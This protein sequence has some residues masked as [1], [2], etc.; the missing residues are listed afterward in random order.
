MPTKCSMKRTTK[1]GMRRTK[2]GWMRKSLDGRRHYYYSKEPW[3]V[4]NE[5]NQEDPIFHDTG[6][7]IH[8]KDHDHSNNSPHNLEKMTVSAHNSYHKKGRIAPNKGRRMSKVQK[9]KISAALTGRRHS[10]EHRRR[11]GAAI[12]GVRKGIS[13]SEEHRRKISAGCMGKKLGKKFSEE[14]RRKL[15]IAH[16]GRIPW[17][18]GM[19]G[20]K[21]NLSI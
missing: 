7:V 16:L 12:K 21:K 11:I 4:W 14:H 3:L 18:K 17:N 6:Y 10:E 20:M 9:L 1:S 2:Q 13:I 5:H 15:S 8:H 19:K